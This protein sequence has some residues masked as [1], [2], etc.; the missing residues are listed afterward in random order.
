[1]DIQERLNAITKEKK[2]KKQQMIIDFDPP[3]ASHFPSGL[4]ATEVTFSEFPFSFFN[5]LPVESC[6][7]L[8]HFLEL[9]AATISPLG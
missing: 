8:I 5:S 9:P 3:V 6:H 1:M 4:N 2:F 7:I